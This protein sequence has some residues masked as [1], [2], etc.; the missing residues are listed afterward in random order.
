MQAID[1]AIGFANRVLE[2]E[3]WARE[4]LSA[5]AGRTMRLICGPM[6]ATL[7][8]AAS[9]LVSPAHALPDLT[10][11]VSPLKVPTLFAH[12]QRWSELVAAEGDAALAATLSDLA[13]TLPWFVEQALAAVFGPL[14]GTR[15]ADAG[16]ALLELPEHA[17]RS[18][19]ASTTGYVRDEA[20]LGVGAAA[21]AGF[22][23][24]IA[25]TAARVDALS[26]RLDQAVNGRSAKA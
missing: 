17:A 7:A 22:S 6:A 2:R 8:I 19:G 18:F 20:R 11:S 13:Q 9:G 24:E 15:V 26:A 12:P 16:R 14:I 10:L 21:F 23:A 5:H 25:A 4:R 3:S 1:P